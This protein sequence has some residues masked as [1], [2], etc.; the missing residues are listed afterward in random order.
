MMVRL[1]TVLTHCYRRTRNSK[2]SLPLPYH[3]M[4]LLMLLI[5]VC[6]TGYHF[7]YI[8]HVYISACWCCCTL[9]WSRWH[10]KLVVTAFIHTNSTCIRRIGDSTFY[11]FPF[12]L[13]DFAR[14][15]LLSIFWFSV[16]CHGMNSFIMNFIEADVCGHAKTV[17][18]G[19]DRL[20]KI[21]TKLLPLVCAQ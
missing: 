15:L 10:S 14:F 7:V 18:N 12:V 9:D 1:Q 20:F 3:R 6:T 8:L 4:A 5:K 13:R 2:R 16:F 17:T 21:A 11:L 19:L